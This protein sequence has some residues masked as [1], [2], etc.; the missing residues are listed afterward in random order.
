MF[1]MGKWFG[2]KKESKEE[3]DIVVAKEENKKVEYKAPKSLSDV[4]EAKEKLEVLKN[5]RKE[6]LREYR[7][8]KDAI[9]KAG[10][11]EFENQD[12]PVKRTNTFNELLEHQEIELEEISQEIEELREEFD[13]QPSHVQRLED[14]RE[15]VRDYIESL[16]KKMAPEYRA[17]KSKIAGFFGSIENVKKGAQ[18]DGQQVNHFLDAIKD[19]ELAEVKSFLIKIHGLNPYENGDKIGDEIYNL[20]NEIEKGIKEHTFYKTPGEEREAY[21]QI[22]RGVRLEDEIVKLLSDAKNKEGKFENKKGHF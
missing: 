9:K 16:E 18:R 20:T 4:V 15:R 21:I 13:L 1:G 10:V 8:T 5:K 22:E 17:V 12:R 11:Q 3:E 19:T 7:Q 14:R 6:Q 2:D